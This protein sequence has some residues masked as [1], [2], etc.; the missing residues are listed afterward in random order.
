M[1]ALVWDG[2]R[3]ETWD[4][5]ELRL[6]G[7]NDV[8][9]EIDVA[10][11][12]HSDLKPIEGDI[13]QPLPVILGHEAV[14][15]VVDRGPEAKTP[16]GTRVVMTVFR[17][18]GV[19]EHC[20][21]GKSINCRATSVTPPS[22]FS[23]GGKTIHQ[24][25]RL[26]TFARRTIVSESQVIPVPS[27]LSDEETAMVSC[28]SVTSFGAVE[29]RA[30]VAPGESVLVIGAGGVGLNAVIAARAAGATKIVVVDLNPRKREISL[31]CGATDFIVASD[32]P[33]RDLANEFALDGF[34]VVLECVGNATLLEE[35]VELLGWGGRLVMVGLPPHGSQ[36]KLD[37]RALFNDKSILG[38]RMGSVSPWQAVPKII[39]RRL[40][41]E[42]DFSPLISRTVRAEEAPSL[43]AS[44]QG[45][46][47]ERGFIS[48]KEDTP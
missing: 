36:M 8:V 5:V 40:A 33:L 25:V 41:G 12:C 37:I 24:F 29:E 19:C 16:L 47:L 46:E 18:C 42:F 43:V 45:G 22:P 15:R 1:R 2:D 17:P 44:L 10:G 6:P 35:A 3:L 34:D 20:V 14:G 48:F 38:S 7:G 27:G 9:V 26:G 11:L 30:R 21:V 13:P 23:R 39:E 32:G 4:D 31:T 28:A